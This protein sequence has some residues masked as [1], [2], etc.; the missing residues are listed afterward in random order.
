M[1]RGRVHVVQPDIGRVGGL[2]EA[3]RVCE[4]ARERGKIVVPHIWKTGI[5]IAAAAHMAA[6][7][8]HCPFIEYLPKDLCESPLRRKLLKTEPSMI[9]GHVVLPD[10]PGL[11]VEIDRDALLHFAE[12]AERKMRD[13]AATPLEFARGK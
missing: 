1:E 11:G 4:S 13:R 9:D 5:L 12:A 2:T 3:W 6:V 7:T 10:L 8:P